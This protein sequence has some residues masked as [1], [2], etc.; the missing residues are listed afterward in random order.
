MNPASGYPARR[1][2]RRPFWVI[3]AVNMNNEIVASFPDGREFAMFREQFPTVL[4]A[5]DDIAVGY[6]A[7][8]TAL[9]E[10]ESSKVTE[11]LFLLVGSSYTEFEEVLM[12]ALNGYGSGATKLL[13][14]LYE[15]TV[16]TQYPFSSWP[17]W[18][19]LGGIGG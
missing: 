13:R 5:L 15:R 8:M 19:S 14:A 7:L 18:T 9:E 3:I 1:T 2:E 12:L 11:I 4:E 6:H 16:T 10:Q 17:A